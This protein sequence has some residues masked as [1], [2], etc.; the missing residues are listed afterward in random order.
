MSNA[1]TIIIHIFLIWFTIRLI[2]LIMNLVLIERRINSLG[3]KIYSFSN[4]LTTKRKMFAFIL[5]NCIVIISLF[6]PLFVVST[7][8]VFLVGCIFSLTVILRSLLVRTL[9]VRNGIYEKGIIL[10]MFIKYKKIRYYKLLNT[11]EIMLSMKNG[12]TL[13]VMV[14]DNINEIMKLFEY[15][16]IPVFQS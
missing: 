8:M 9:S 6:L 5:F 13:N 14:N 3:K 11:G 15:N 4:F 10:G 16:R 1:R 12:R 2:Y 7:D